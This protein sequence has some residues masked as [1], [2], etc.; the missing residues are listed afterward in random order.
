MARRKS[1]SV[2]NQEIVN[3]V[4]VSK[5]DVENI[6]KNHNVNIMEELK[7]NIDSEKFNVI[8]EKDE[9]PE[10][11]SEMKKAFEEALEEELSTSEEIEAEEKEDEVPVKKIID[12]KPTKEQLMKLSKSGFRFYLRTG[13]L[14]R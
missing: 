3:N 1:K 8:E 5:E 7:K 9:S 10:I 2:L 14:P 12:S 6:E 13:K 11:T 4:S